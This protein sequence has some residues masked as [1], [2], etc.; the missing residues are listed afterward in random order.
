MED[1]PAPDMRPHRDPVAV[2]LDG[3]Q[4]TEL[5]Y[6]FD[7]FPSLSQQRPGWTELMQYTINLTNSALSRQ[8]PYRIPE[9]LLN[10]LKAEIEIMKDLGFIDAPTS[11]WSSPFVIVPKKD[12]S[13]CVCVDFLNAQSS[14]NCCC[15]DHSGFHVLSMLFQAVFFC[16]QFMCV[17]YLLEFGFISPSDRLWIIFS[18]GSVDSSPL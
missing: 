11:E 18:C 17:W 4:Q 10:P 15:V 8:W 13:L 1:E 14:T 9:R 7:N 16:L 6:L 2:T 5:R 3:P 12:G